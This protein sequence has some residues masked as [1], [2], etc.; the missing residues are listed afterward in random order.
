MGYVDELRKTR[1]RTEPVEVEVDHEGYIWLNMLIKFDT[2]TGKS[3]IVRSFA[4]PAA[5]SKIKMITKP[6]KAKK[7]Q[8]KLD[9]KKPTVTSTDLFD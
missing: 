9:I 4:K 6:K 7:K 1:P 2:L 8:I 3:E 5:E